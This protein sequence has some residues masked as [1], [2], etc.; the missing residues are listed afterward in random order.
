MGDWN[1]LYEACKNATGRDVN[2][3]WEVME[4][5]EELHEKN[6]M[7]EAELSK[8]NLTAVSGRSEQVNCIHKTSRLRLI[9]RNLTCLDC[10]TTWRQL[11]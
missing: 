11:T 7:L 3:V 10:K 9:G 8:L 5:V 4:V 2:D 6:I 1:R